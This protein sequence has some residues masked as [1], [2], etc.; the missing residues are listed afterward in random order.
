MRQPHQPPL[1]PPPSQDPETGKPVWR[2]SNEPRPLDASRSNDSS[3]T[4]PWSAAGL[5]EP[6]WWRAF[7]VDSNVVSTRTP[8]LV[9]QDRSGS[10]GTNRVPPRLPPPRQP[11]LSQAPAAESPIQH[12]I[13]QLLSAFSPPS[14]K[15]APSPVQTS[16]S[17]PKPLE[18]GGLPPEKWSSLMYGF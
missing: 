18:G 13:D 7:V 12:R 4:S 9:H 10:N 8:V 11:V 14:A 6:G 1:R 3:L 16:P 17:K 5:P 2:A 15:E